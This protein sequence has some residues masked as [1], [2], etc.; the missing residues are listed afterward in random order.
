MTGLGSFSGSGYSDLTFSGE[1]IAD[2]DAGVITY[3][4]VNGLRFMNDSKL[5]ILLAECNRPVL[6]SNHKKPIFR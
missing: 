6:L 2:T 1:E 3:P 4:T 5:P